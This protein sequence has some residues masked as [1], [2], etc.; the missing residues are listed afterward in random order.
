MNVEYLD[1]GLTGQA[2]KALKTLVLGNLRPPLEEFGCPYLH[3]S[4][5]FSSGFSYTCRVFLVV[6]DLQRTLKSNLTMCD[7]IRLHATW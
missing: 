1:L 3:P 5:I 7:V 2:L 6:T 4:N